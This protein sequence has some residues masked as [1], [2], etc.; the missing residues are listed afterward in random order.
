MPKSSVNILY[1]DIRVGFKI[2]GKYS[3]KIETCINL[4]TWEEL[5]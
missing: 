3:F 1:L 5:I 2:E 4:I